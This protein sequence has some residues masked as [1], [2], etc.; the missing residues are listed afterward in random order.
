MKR[1]KYIYISAFALAVSLSACNKVL[2]IK[3]K[4]TIDQSTAIVTSD[5][6]Q[7]TLVG[8]YNRT[9]VVDVLGGRMQMEQDLLATQNILD[10]NGTYLELAQMTGQNI[11]NNNI[12]VEYTWQYSYQAINLANNVIANLAKADADQRDRMEGEAKFIRGTLYFELTREF[13]RAWND[14]DPNVNLGVP[15]VTTPTTTVTSASYVSRA[16]VKQCYDQAISDLKTA[17][18]KLPETNSFYAGKYAASAILARLYLQQGDYA[19]ALTEANTVITSAQ[20][21]LTAKY[22]DEFPIPG[23]PTHVDNTTEDIFAMQ[24]TEQQGTN[25]LNEFYAS[26]GNGGRGDLRVH[27]DFVAGFA[28]TDT[29]GQFFT[30]RTNDDGSVA[31]YRTKKFDN[32]YGNVHVVRLAEMYLIRAEA[33][34]A[35]GSAT[36]ASPLSDVNK[37]RARAGITPLTTVTLAAILTERIHELCFEGGFALHDAKRLKQPVNGLL[38]SSPKLIFPI[39]QQELLANKNLVQNQGY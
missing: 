30:A 1:T 33:N 37:I 6:V 11:A 32:T 22:S 36:G 20:Y 12:F 4:E 27:T 35:K 39:P 16:T 15:I 10:F 21:S 7:S 26:T 23:K 34:L 13:G 14:G 2:D 9:A 8:A 29:R 3:P 28:A 19:N 38:Y 5:D 17:E 25:G 24:V 18:S 31:F